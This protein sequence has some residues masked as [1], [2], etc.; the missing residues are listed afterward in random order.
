[1]HPTS[2]PSHGTAHAHL[3]R[4]LGSCRREVFEAACAFRRQ[5]EPH[6]ALI[7]L[8]GLAE[9]WVD[10]SHLALL[11]PP[12]P[13][14]RLGEDLGLD[15]LTVIELGLAAEEALGRDALRS[16]SSPPRTLGD[17]VGRFLP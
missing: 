5:P 4:L 8:A 11:R 15:S 17:L 12:H 1:M 10:P 14:I 13:A 3:H 9:R 6:L 7:V 2:V 16:D